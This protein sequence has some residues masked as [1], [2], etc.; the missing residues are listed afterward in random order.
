MAYRKQSGF[1]LLELMITVAVLGVLAAIALPSFQSI[2][3]HRRLAG[4]A[5]NLFADLQYARSESI[6]RNE[7]I[8]VQVTSGASWCFGLDDDDGVACLCTSNACEIGGVVK[9]VTANSYPNIEM[10]EGGVIEFDPRQGLLVPSVGEDFIF[11]IGGA[12]GDTR[13]VSISAL[14]RVSMD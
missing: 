5:E 2:I 14:G 1:T 3:E 8:R 11:R 9:N 4:A 13:T 6:K 12:G 10:S 7:V